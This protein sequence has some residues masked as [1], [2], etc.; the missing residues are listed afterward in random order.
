V[1]EGALALRE[2]TPP[3]DHLVPYVLSGKGAIW[4]RF[5]ANCEATTEDA[6]EIG[7]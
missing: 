4:L 3:Y 6:G 5:A 2:L 7:S 1:S